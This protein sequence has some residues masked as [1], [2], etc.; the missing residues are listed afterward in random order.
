ML[1]NAIYT[2]IALD[3]TNT[4]VNAVLEI[5]EH[6]DIFKGHFPDH[7]VLPGACMLQIVKEVFEN[8]MGKNYQLQKADN[9]KFLTLI[10]P[11]KNNILH[12]EI[13]YQ[14]EESEIKVTANLATDEHVAFKFQGS[15]MA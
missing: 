6:N 2:V 7:P 3:H 5:N 8:V 1:N 15:F 14:I 10:D 9:L 11:Q 12:L 13:N 4:A